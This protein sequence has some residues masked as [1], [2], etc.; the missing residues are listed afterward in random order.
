MESSKVHL[1]F[2][3]YIDVSVC[4]C[5]RHTLIHFGVC[6][7]VLLRLCVCV[8]NMANKHTKCLFRHFQNFLCSFI[9]CFCTF[10]QGLTVL[11]DLSECMSCANICQMAP[12]SAKLFFS[13][14]F[15]RFCLNWKWVVAFRFCIFFYCWIYIFLW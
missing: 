4:V 3:I 13:H 9:L 10:F 15:K 8:F 1:F 11:R 2:I 5:V 12:K 14:F 7:W 6:K